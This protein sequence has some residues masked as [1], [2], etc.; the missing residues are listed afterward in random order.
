MTFCGW[1]QYSEF[2]SG[3]CHRWLDDPK[4]PVPIILK[5]S[6]EEGGPK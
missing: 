5:A 1:G 2:P 4:K 3:L 6:V